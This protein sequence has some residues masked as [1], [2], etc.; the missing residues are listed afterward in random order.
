MHG[1]ENVIDLPHKEKYPHPHMWLEGSFSSLGRDLLSKSE[2]SPFF[3]LLELQVCL[4]N[5]VNIFWPLVIN[6]ISAKR[7]LFFIQ[8]HCK[9]RTVFWERNNPSFS[10]K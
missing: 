6:C 8:F 7:I 5:R 10:R 9:S 3:F 1:K 2:K 4:V